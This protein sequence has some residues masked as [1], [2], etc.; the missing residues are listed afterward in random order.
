MVEGNGLLSRGGVVSPA[1]GFESRS[2]RCARSSVRT[3]RWPAEPE[4]SGSSPDGRT[5][6]WKIEVERR[7]KRLNRRMRP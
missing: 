3:E 7:K 4:V 6:H 5:I 2:L 1:P